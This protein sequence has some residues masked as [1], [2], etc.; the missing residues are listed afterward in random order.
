M[1]GRVEGEGITNVEQRM[2]NGEGT[3]RTFDI[4]H[5]PFDIRHSILSPTPNLSNPH[6]FLINNYAIEFGLRGE[7]T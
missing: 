4:R 1:Y 6:T 2:S 3:H 7:A 5:S